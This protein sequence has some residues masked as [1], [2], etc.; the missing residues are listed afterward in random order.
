M[1]VIFQG[2]GGAKIFESY[3][4]NISDLLVIVNVKIN[5]YI[6]A[7]LSMYKINHFLC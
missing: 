3:D 5:M 1:K 7:C 2:E 4:E 6:F